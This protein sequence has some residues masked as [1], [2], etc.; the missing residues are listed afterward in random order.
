MKKV[1]PYQQPD[2]HRSILEAVN[3]K[4]ARQWL[5]KRM[6]EGTFFCE[7]ELEKAEVIEIHNSST[8]AVQVGAF[9]ADNKVYTT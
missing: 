1:Y 4:D 6:G 2:G 9:L 3:L 5:K 8:R 7:I